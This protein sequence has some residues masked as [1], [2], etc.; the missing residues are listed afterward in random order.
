MTK[1]CSKCKIKKDI[2]HFGKLY[3]SKDG[4]RH[5]C[6]E[7]RK[8]ESKKRYDENKEY[9]QNYNKIN[10]QKRKK[11]RKE[12]YNKNKKEIRNK[13]K[14]YYEENKVLLNEKMKFYRKENREVL[15]EYYRKRRLNDINYDIEVRIRNRIN[16]AIKN[17]SNSTKELLGCSMDPYIMY[18]EER[19]EDGMT[20]ENRS[21][22]HIDHIVPINNFDLTDEKQVLKAFNYKN[23]QPLWAKDNLSKNKW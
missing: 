15:N 6:K 21:K 7:C 18:L 12:N 20:W 23:T 4:Y 9:F 8:K 22:W 11:Y 3:K 1:I 5:E 16:V 2:S 14:K 19:F 17:K 10:K 13:Q